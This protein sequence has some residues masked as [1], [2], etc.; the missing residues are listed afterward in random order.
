VCCA[1]PTTAANR[2]HFKFSHHFLQNDMPSSRHSREGGNLFC[3]EAKIEALV[4]IPAFAGMTAS[5]LIIYPIA[6]NS[7][8]CD[9]YI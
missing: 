8:H 3:I 6:D 2:A 9:N 1:T 7:F 5:M 4:E